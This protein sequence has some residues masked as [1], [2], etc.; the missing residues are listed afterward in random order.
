MIENNLDFEIMEFSDDI[1]NDNNL[2]DKIQTLNELDEQEDDDNDL[3]NP[4]LIDESNLDELDLTDE[5]KKAILKKKEEK[6]KKTTEESEETEKSDEEEEESEEEGDESPLK[7]FAQELAEK[8]LLDLPEEW[9][10]DE[11]ALYEAYEKTL[12][13]RA[14]NI[15]KNAYKVDDPRV[16]GVLNFLKNGGNIDDY[17]NLHAETN[18]VDVDIEDEDN[19]TA[20]VKTY[21]QSVKGLEEE[22]AEELVE[23]YKEKN[24]LFIQATKIQSDLQKYREKQEEELI[25]SQ[26][27]YAKIQR[28]EYAKTVNKIRETIKVGKSDNVVIAKNQ[29]TNLEDFIFSPMDIKDNKGQVVGRATGF[30]KVL[31]EYLSDPE[32]M[33]A[34]AYK[35]YE[36][37]SDKSEKVEIESKVR[38][39][40]ADSIKKTAGKKKEST[41]FKIEFIN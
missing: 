37:L 21:L 18:W 9:E 13:D 41:D 4:D 39:K 35:L 36:G 19:A 33:V 2:T 7:I 25:K 24:K 32:K 11:E 5:E 14:L 31:N 12:E 27:E 6:A 34:L 1:L 10:G 8:N 28:E 26:E 38:S 30:K 29:K 40:L 15:V 17:I 3:V 20:L 23:G 22:E 16:D